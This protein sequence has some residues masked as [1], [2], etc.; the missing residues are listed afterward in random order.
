MLGNSIVT[1]ATVLWAVS[2]DLG[3]ISRKQYVACQ[4]GFNMLLC[5]FFKQ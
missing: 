1:G 5:L 2:V 4:V 3:G